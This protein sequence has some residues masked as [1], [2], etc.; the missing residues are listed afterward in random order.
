MPKDPPWS[1]EEKDALIDLAELSRRYGGKCPDS[2]LAQKMPEKWQE[3]TEPPRVY[4]VDCIHGQIYSLEKDPEY[5]RRLPARVETMH[6]MA[7]TSSDM[8]AKAVSRALGGGMHVPPEPAKPARKARDS[9]GRRHRSAAPSPDPVAPKS[10]TNSHQHAR[11]W[12]DG[13]RNT[14]REQEVWRDDGLIELPPMDGPN[15][16]DALGN[17][18]L[19]L[20]PIRKAALEPR[21]GG[22]PSGP[23][24]A[25]GVWDK[26]SF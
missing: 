25:P 16:W 3:K 19:Q 23:G 20:G 7:M 4:T 9:R 26:P 10:A 8:A 24:G 18:R 21:G 13:T 2:V 22:K 12:M 5:S 14:I 17:I 11:V 6:S 1:K 15:D